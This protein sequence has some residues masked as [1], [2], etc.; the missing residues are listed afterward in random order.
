M[1]VS[2]RELLRTAAGTLVATSIAGR[3]AAEPR[4]GA[5]E[6]EK[7]LPTAFDALKPIGDQ[8]K[9]I[10]VD[11][12]KSRIARAQ[13]I[14]SRA[15]PAYSALFVAP[16][17]SLRYFT[18][19]RWE[20]SERLVALLVPHEGEPLIVC[21]AFEEGR[22]REQLR[23]PIQVRVWQEDQSPYGVAGKWLAER[24]MRTGRI[25]IEEATRYAFFDGLRKNFPYPEYLIGDTISAGCRARKSE[26]ELALMRLACTATFGVFK[27]VFASLKEGMTQAETAALV[28]RGFAKMG[29]EGGALVLFGPS[30]ALPH[31]THEEQRIKDGVGALIDGGTEVEGY[32][33]DVTRT[34]AFGKPPDKLQRAFD[35]V[36]K[37]QDAA[38]AA[39]VA[40]KTCGSVDDAAR[41]MVTRGGFGP[42]YKYFTHRL[43]HGI[44]L[45]EHEQ[46]Y[47]VHGN[48]TILAPNMTFSNEPGIYVR[49]DY[50]L[51]LEDDM[52]IA[53]SGG[54]QLLTPGFAPSLTTPIA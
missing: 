10:T 24:H 35:V 32:K 40:G 43:G 36:R 13:E 47:L 44:G 33:S 42:G 31:G 3:A 19:I 50:G 45:D 41:V 7:K 9:P 5:A 2:R 25:A 29:L 53:A 34:S 49:G 30:A 8:V 22:L 48:R 27:A 39:A 4:M 6:Q 46:P 54:A 15:K 37:A 28:Y 18:G 16:G 20:V 51:R 17:T 26:A 23:W 1:R 21:P 14:M 52:A 12:F 11:E 38:L